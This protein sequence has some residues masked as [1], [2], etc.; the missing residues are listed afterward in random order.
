M[1]PVPCR[2]SSCQ[3]AAD[4]VVLAE[5]NKPAQRERRDASTHHSAHQTPGSAFLNPRASALFSLCPPLAPLPLTP[6][7]QLIHPA[8]A[9]LGHESG[10]CMTARNIP[11]HKC[12][13][14]ASTF[15][16]LSA[17]RK[18]RTECASHF[19]ECVNNFWL[20]GQTSHPGDVCRVWLWLSAY[21][22]VFYPSLMCVW[23]FFF[24]FFYSLPLAPPT[25]HLDV[26]LSTQSRRKRAL[27][28]LHKLIRGYTQERAAAAWTSLIMLMRSPGDAVIEV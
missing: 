14:K 15:V 22:C 17:V 19:S 18:K 20:A 3:T 24:S 16:T 7:L 27:S 23:I 10:L 28:F 13:P 8:L 4:R 6:L 2:H 1:L 9:T 26:V 5:K 12:F 11:C 21:V 25:P